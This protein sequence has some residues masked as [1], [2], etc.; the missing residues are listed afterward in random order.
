MILPNLM[1]IIHI[2]ETRRKTLVV[3]G[4]KPLTHAGIFR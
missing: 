2:F 4:T 1:K 3:E